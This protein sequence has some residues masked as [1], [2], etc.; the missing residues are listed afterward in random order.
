MVEVWVGFIGVAG[1]VLGGLVGATT[2]ELLRRRNRIEGYSPNV[3]DKRLQVYEELLTHMREGSKVAY[4]IMENVEFSVEQ[5]HAAI[6][7]VVLDIASFT[8]EN[9]LYIDWELAGHCVATF[10][11]AEDILTIA[12]EGERS[13]AQQRITD[14]YKD[15]RRMIRE[16]SGVAGIERLIKTVA[17]PKLSGAFIDLLRYEKK[18]FDNK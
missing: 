14:M 9:E 13:Q 16:D 3:F 18:R 12:D 4:E 6:S 15:A 8:D 7:V 17:K 1:T 5:R 10:M 2:N 11:G